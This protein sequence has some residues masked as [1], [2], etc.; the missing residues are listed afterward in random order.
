MATFLYELVT[1][2][3][4]KTPEAIALQL[5]QDQLSYANL[6]QQIHQ[7]ANSYSALN[8][9]R[10]DRIGIYLH[11]TFEHVV[12][13]FACSITGA[14]L[15]PINP[16]LKAHQV[17]HIVNDC[18]IK[19]LI[20]NQA[21]LNALVPLLPLLPSLLHIIVTDHENQ[22]DNKQ[23]QQAASLSWSDF[24]AMQI[25]VKTPVVQTSND[26]AAILYTSGST[27]SPKGVVLSHNNIVCG[28]KSVATYLGNTCDDNILAVL[29]LSFD[30][31]LSQLT[32]AFLVGACC[33]LLDYLLPNDVLIAIEKHQITGL[34]AVPPLW[35]QLCHLHWPKG[36]AD[37]VRYFTNSGGV[38]PRHTLT[39][40]RALMPNADPYLMY[41]LTEAF[42]STYLVPQEIDN[43]IG[44]MGKAIPN[45]EILVV[46]KDGSECAP[47]EPGELVHK[48]PLVSLGYWNKR[49]KT[50]Q[51]FKPA[52]HPIK[53]QMTTELAVWS[54]DTV[55]K[56]K[57][58]FLYFVARQ[59]EMIKTSGYRVSPTEI[60]EVLYQ[61]DAITEAVAIGVIHHELGQAI[62]AIVCCP[63]ELST[64]KQLEGSIAK[65]CQQQLA[66]FMIPKKILI[67]NELPHNG[68]GKIDRNLLN[69]TYNNLFNN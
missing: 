5:H 36:I 20:T 17:K 61:H 57:D 25:D 1:Q 19:L 34:A 30:Y 48:G 47:G 45:A 22:L 16:V 12:S 51:R 64:L 44:S 67:V 32:S 21:R 35:A 27:G 42:R 29:P 37:S 40:L 3:A 31:G 6:S 38:L 41:G 53:Q 60:E 4:N 69:L 23:T 65:H 24:Y 28:A 56:D 59:D 14:V 9:G 15:V 54:G 7:V 8:I 49:D 55:Q 43:R 52:P 58:G 13:A 68:N 10:F 63:K 11:K 46:R 33:T 26:I 39:Q 50:N 66:N 18:E 62:I 2:S